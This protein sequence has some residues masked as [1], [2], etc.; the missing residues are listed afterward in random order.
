M[1]K[2]LESLFLLAGSICCILVGMHY[3]LA[4]YQQF[5]QVQFMEDAQKTIKMQM[6]YFEEHTPPDPRLN[7]A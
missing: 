6:E 3:G 7:T 2:M 4:V 5:K 1:R